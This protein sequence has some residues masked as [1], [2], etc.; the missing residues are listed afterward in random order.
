MLR[1]QQYAQPDVVVIDF[2]VT[3]AMGATQ[4]QKLCGTP[5]YIPPETFRERQWF[6]GGDVFSMGV[7]MFQMLTGTTPPPDVKYAHETKGLFLEDCRT[8]EQVVE[9]TA[10]RQP[11]YELMPAELP[12]LVQLTRRVL[13]KDPKVRPRA[14]KVLTDDWFQIAR[15]S[16]EADGRRKTRT[17]LR[18]DSGPV[19]GRH[20][21]ATEG[22][23][24]E[25]MLAKLYN[26]L[27]GQ[28]E[29]IDKSV[30]E[31][32]S[33][34]SFSTVCPDQSLLATESDMQEA[35]AE[36]PLQPPSNEASPLRVPTICEISCTP[37]RSVH[38]QTARGR[39]TGEKPDANKLRRNRSCDGLPKWTSASEVKSALK[40]PAT[41]IA[42]IDC[43]S[44]FPER[45]M[46]DTR[47]PGSTTTSESNGMKPAL[48]KTLQQRPT[49][50]AATDG[51]QQTAPCRQSL[52]ISRSSNPTC[53]SQLASS[54]TPTRLAFPHRPGARAVQG[55]A[56]PVKTI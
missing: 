46:V 43:T 27:A 18:R 1:D 25:E 41:D 14:P 44:R 11:R 29:T 8:M 42:L 6:P 36:P 38:P 2:G 34:S 17:T 3:K 28:K 12:G 54:A 9:A 26:S 13:E 4:K 23:I 33:G 20:R 7:V 16:P 10:T 55:L 30:V 5:G 56:V 51:T 37:R 22:R 50:T 19:I 53:P 31:D 49:L 52:S 40:R 32:D 48:K 21:M 24:P 39:E 15:A 47:L 45:L 35:D